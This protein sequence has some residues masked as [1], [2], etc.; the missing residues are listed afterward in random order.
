MF[1]NSYTLPLSFLKKQNTS[2]IQSVLDS[3]TD[4]EANILPN[5]P[6]VDTT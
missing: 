5:V 2:N 3:V 6:W 1:L 4:L